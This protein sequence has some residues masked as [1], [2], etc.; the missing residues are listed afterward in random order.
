MSSKMTQKERLI[1]LAYL[2]QGKT[3]REVETL[4]P[5]VS[6]PQALRLRK[7]LASAVEA[8]TLNELFNLEEAALETLLESVEDELKEA[9]EV[10][11][12]DLMPLNNALDSIESRIKESKL[13]ELELAKAGQTLARQIE[14]HSVIV[15]SPESLLA[16]AEALAKLQTAYFKNSNIQIANINNQNGEN[17]AGSFEDLLTK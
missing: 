17:P 8:N 11:T 3:P 2:H 14:R 1:A 16:L 9:A 4:C 13:L 12:G 15:N 7:E 10:M 5:G 6:Y